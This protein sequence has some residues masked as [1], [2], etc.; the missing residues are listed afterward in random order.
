MFRYNKMNYLIFKKMI[1]IK[2]KEL[3]LPKFKEELLTIQLQWLE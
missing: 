3:D 2:T 1:E